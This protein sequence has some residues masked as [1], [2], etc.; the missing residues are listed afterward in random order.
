[1]LEIFFPSMLMFS[2]LHCLPVHSS[3]LQLACSV[4]WVFSIFECAFSSF[5]WMSLPGILKYKPLP[6][7]VCLCAVMTPTVCPCSSLLI[8]IFC[9]WLTEQRFF[10]H[11][12]LEP[13]S[14]WAASCQ[15]PIYCWLH[16]PRH[17][18]SSILWPPR[19]GPGMLRAFLPTLFPP[20]SST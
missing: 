11:H 15:T 9:S 6:D 8:V 3:F 19:A 2:F 14:F 7:Y 4:S 10:P 16:C 20:V 13:T 18:L 12:C 1:M 5:L 17:V